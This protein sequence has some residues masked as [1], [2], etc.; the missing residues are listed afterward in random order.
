MSHDTKPMYIFEPSVVYFA[1][2]GPILNKSAL[3]TQRFGTTKMIWSTV[4]VI[5][6]VDLRDPFEDNDGALLAILGFTFL[7]GSE[8]V[9]KCVMVV[10]VWPGERFDGEG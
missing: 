7:L 5:V 2:T 1:N 6:W 3:S 10:R 8:S 4:P 9:L